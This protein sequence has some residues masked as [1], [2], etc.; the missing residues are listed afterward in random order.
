MDDVGLWLP[1]GFHF[2]P[3]TGFIRGKEGAIAQED[4][5]A[6]GVFEKSKM[7]IQVRMATFGRANAK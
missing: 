7:A 1:S 5:A 3:K 6:C 2:E 4:S